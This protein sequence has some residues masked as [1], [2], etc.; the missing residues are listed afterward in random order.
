[1]DYLK[2]LKNISITKEDVVSIPQKK[3]DTFQSVVTNEL[4]R[5]YIY[6][7]LENE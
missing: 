6:N 7:I 3:V 2:E 1:M 5:E 4:K